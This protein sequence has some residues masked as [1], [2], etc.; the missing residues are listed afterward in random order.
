M[1][2]ALLFLNDSRRDSRH[3][4]STRHDSHDAITHIIVM[5]GHCWPAAMGSLI[6]MSDVKRQGL[7]DSVMVSGLS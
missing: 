7:S 5:L 4:G 6:E 3:A 1:H 2:N